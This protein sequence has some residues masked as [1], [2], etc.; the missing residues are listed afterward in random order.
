MGWTKEFYMRISIIGTRGIPANYGGF[1][2]FAENIAEKLV[3]N[4][5][6]VTVYC[7]SH[8]VDYSKVGY[9]YK[10]V[11]LVVLPTI[12]HKYLDTVFHTFLSILHSLFKNYEV[13][14][15]CNSVNSLFSFLPRILG[16][17]VV[18]NVDGLEWKRAKWNKLGKWVYR[19]SEYLATFLPD[20]IVTDSIS[21]KDYY[22][23]KFLKEIK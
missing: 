10:G 5:H 21:I 3:D 12:K 18:L 7:R 22:K 9:L 1:E 8:N 16:K 2:T 23:N 13:I 11:K 6:E 20:M 14:L 4:G 15:I 19:T 17:R